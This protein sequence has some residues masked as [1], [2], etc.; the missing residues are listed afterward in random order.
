MSKE[1]VEYLRHILDE[2]HYIG[3][4]ITS[5][6]GCCTQQDSRIDGTNSEVISEETFF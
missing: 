2:C 6:F 5:L 4:V 3:S 1:P